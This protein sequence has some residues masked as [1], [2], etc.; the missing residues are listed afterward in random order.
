MHSFENH[1]RKYEVAGE[2]IQKSCYRK[3]VEASK[4]MKHET[5]VYRMIAGHVFMGH[6]CMKMTNVLGTAT[7]VQ[8]IF[9]LLLKPGRWDLRED[10]WIQE[11]VDLWRELPP[12]G[13]RERHVEHNQA[14]WRATSRYHHLLQCVTRK[15]QWQWCNTANQRLPALTITTPTFQQGTVQ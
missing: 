12:W 4:Q 13:W 3:H 6:L 2:M 10:S 8:H 11:R 7:V 15:E 1:T 5:H 14:R 9:L